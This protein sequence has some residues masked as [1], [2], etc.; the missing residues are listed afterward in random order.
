L[1]L[2]RLTNVQIVRLDASGPW[3][4]SESGEEK[5]R[6]GY[7]RSLCPST[8]VITGMSIFPSSLDRPHL[9]RLI[10]ENFYGELRRLVIVFGPVAND[11][12]LIQV[13]TSLR[14]LL[15]DVGHSLRESDVKGNAILPPVDTYP[16]LSN[17]PVTLDKQPT[18]AV[19][20]PDLTIHLVRLPMVYFNNHKDL[21][22][23]LLGLSACV[24]VIRATEERGVRYTFVNMASDEDAHVD[25]SVWGTMFAATTSV[26]RPT[27]IRTVLSMRQY[28]RG[29]GKGLLRAEDLR[30]AGFNF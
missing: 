1:D 21:N 30:R 2:A 7:L 19:L 28:I 23:T 20:R 6:F 4:S 22:Y 5:S 14:H 8:L 10:E 29:V 26:I 27:A 24:P 9:F 12:P 17:G 15:L 18:Q 3:R 16:P 25:T 13:A 11:R